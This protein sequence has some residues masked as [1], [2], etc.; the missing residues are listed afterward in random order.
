MKREEYLNKLKFQLIDLPAE[1]LKQIEDFYEELIYDGMEQ[2]YTEEELLAKMESPE[3]V[4]QKIRAEYG[5]LVVYTAK[6]KSREKTQKGFKS[7][8]MIHTVK[9]ETESLSIRIR[10][11]EEGPI[12]ACF[13]PKEGQNRVEFEEKDGVFYLRQEAKGGLLQSWLNLFLE[14]DILV[15]EI[16]VNFAGNLWLKTG[17]G[18]IKVSGLANLARADLFSENGKIRVENSQIGTIEIGSGNGKLD[19]TNAIG[20]TLEASS[21]NGLV[22]VKECRFLQKLSLITKNGAIT[23]RNL[24]SDEIVMQTYNGFLNGTII[25]NSNDYNINSTT[26]NGINNLDNVFD[27]KRHKSLTAH[28]HN[29]WIQIEF[30]P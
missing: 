10:T 5:G 24:I 30:K 17:N 7:S 23:G 16:P 19:I 12:R 9:V 4:A 29:G 8:E 20:D 18:S 28:T 22:T 25:G 14:F 2:G 6:A 1:D 26:R 21:N 13:K 27:P 15:L 3:E 11:V